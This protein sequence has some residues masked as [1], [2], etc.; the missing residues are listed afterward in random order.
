MKRKIVTKILC[1]TMICSIMI[2]TWPVHAEITE[3]YVEEPS[4]DELVSLDD[5]EI[6]DELI[7]QRVDA[8]TEGDMKRYYELTEELKKHGCED[9]SFQEVRQLTGN[10]PNN[11]LNSK[12]R[13]TYNT[14]NSGI[15]LYGA[16]A[17]N[18][19]FS[20]TYSTVKYN[21]K[22]YKIMKITASPTGRGTLYK[23]GSVT[24]SYN[25]PIKAG[26]LNLLKVIVN[27]ALSKNKVVKWLS[28]LDAAAGVP[29]KFNDTT[30]VE[31][32]EANYTWVTEEICSFVY[33]Y[34]ARIKNYVIG[35]SYNKAKY[36]VAMNIP[37][38]K[39]KNGKRY[40]G[41]QQQQ[42]TDW[43]TSAN[44]GSVR[45]AVRY[46]NKGTTYNS[47]IYNVKMDGCK[48]QEIHN[49]YLLHPSTAMQ[50]GYWN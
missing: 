29:G 4:E 26:A 28:F 22:K 27:T 40:S 12:A 14:F 10:T 38:F 39:I 37:Y 43:L 3:N 34:D 9:V 41:I 20:T 2:P 25:K 1:F 17:T 35:A 23:T 21:G 5:F 18:V 30:K 16:A 6:V 32:I 7:E 13:S 49:V 11:L 42:Y 48:D 50:L 45:A 33:V 15:S 44:Y 46:F 36:V 24:K 47:W 8:L 19:T 31:G